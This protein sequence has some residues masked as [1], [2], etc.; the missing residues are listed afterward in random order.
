V[1]S[2]LVVDDEIGIAEAVADLL[3]DEGYRVDLARN[4]HDALELLKKKGYD[5]VIA[6]WMM[7]IIDGHGLITAMRRMPKRK[8]IPVIVMSALPEKVVRGE[9]ECDA[10]LRKP[11]DVDELLRLVHRLAGNET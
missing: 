2:L 10:F 7:P 9:I 4:G 1:K 8:D 6:D 5:L 11:F 3:G